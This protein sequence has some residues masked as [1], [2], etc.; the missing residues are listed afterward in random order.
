MKAL[1]ELHSVSVVMALC[2]GAFN[3]PSGMLTISARKVGLDASVLGSYVA[4][5][6]GEY[7]C[8]EHKSL[9]ACVFAGLYHLDHELS[10][11]V[12]KQLPLPGTGE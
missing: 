3:G 6:S 10:A 1:E 7:P 11:K 5:L 2:P 9:E 4:A 8:K 12:W